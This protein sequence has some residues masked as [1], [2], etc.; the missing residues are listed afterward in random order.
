[1][2]LRE[3]ET[4][5]EE[6]ERPRRWRWREGERCAWAWGT[7][8]SV[9]LG[10]SGLDLLLGDSCWGVGGCELCSGCCECSSGAREGERDLE[11]SAEDIVGMFRLSRYRSSER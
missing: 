10:W 8:E 9:G 3:A 4:G 2:G 5:R 1:M 11:C 6:R 7:E